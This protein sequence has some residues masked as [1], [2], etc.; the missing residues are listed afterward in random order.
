MPKRAIAEAKLNFQCIA[1]VYL[2]V[3]TSSLVDISMMMR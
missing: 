3:S 1:G 2:D